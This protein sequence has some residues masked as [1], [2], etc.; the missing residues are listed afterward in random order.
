VHKGTLVFLPVAYTMYIL[1]GTVD[2][3][4]VTYKGLD[5]GGREQVHKVTL[6]MYLLPPSPTR[7]AH[8]CQVLTEVWPKSSAIFANCSA[9][10]LLSIKGLLFKLPPPPP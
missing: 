5:G 1:Y 8:C 6:R 9:T 10:S 7:T 3:L 2:F 4:F